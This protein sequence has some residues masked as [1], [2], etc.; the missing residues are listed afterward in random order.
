M[1]VIT[2]GWTS[3]GLVCILLSIMMWRWLAKPGVYTI[4]AV[5]AS[6]G[7]TLAVSGTPTSL[8]LLV[9]AMFLVAGTWWVVSLPNRRLINTVWITTILVVFGLSK[10]TFTAPYFGPAVWIGISYIFLRLIHITLEARQGRLGKV[11]LSQ[12]MIYVLHPATLVA[13]PIDRIQHSIDEQVQPLASKSRDQYFNEGFWRILSGLVKK[14]I[15]ANAFYGISIAFDA[16]HTLPST[17]VAWI[18]LISY[19]FY[20]Y[21]DF[22]A[23]S[24]IAIGAGLWLGIRLP[25]NFTNPYL[26]PSIT[27]FWQS[28][29]ITL[30]SWLRDYVFFPTSRSLLRRLGNRFTPLILLISHLT[31][32]VV[33]GLWHGFRLELVAW[34]LWHGM[35][36]YLHNR[37]STFRRRY[38]LPMIPTVV[39]VGVTYLFVS[40]G[41]VFFSM[42]LRHAGRILIRLLG[43]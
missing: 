1:S 37:W 36:L 19:S 32:M 20:I 23:Y 17:L 9:V 42:P 15:L 43:I 16:I 21:F 26:Q 33:S 41:W 39:G 27:Q 31:T 40:F 6:A 8:L 28:W 25:E 4:L 30:S 29:H 14:I 5:C 22:A 2:L 18:W 12:M 13:G 34:G 3:A 38:H 10:F 24:D 7:I 35:G 11:P